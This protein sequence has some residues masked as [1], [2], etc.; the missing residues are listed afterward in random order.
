MFNVLVRYLLFSCWDRGVIFLSCWVNWIVVAFC[1]SGWFCVCANFTFLSLKSLWGSLLSYLLKTR[2]GI[3][4]TSGSQWLLCMHKDSGTDAREES[5]ILEIDIADVSQWLCGND[6][7]QDKVP[8]ILHGCLGLLS[9]RGIQRR[10]WCGN[11]KA[12]KEIKGKG[13]DLCAVGGF[14]TPLETY[15][16]K[17]AQ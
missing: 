9:N 10:G 14:G 16:I 7:P 15:L 17:G 11:T 12:W 8:T 6:A 5:V 13:G 2:G 3:G 1:T 4:I